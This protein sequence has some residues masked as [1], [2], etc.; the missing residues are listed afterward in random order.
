V[1]GRPVTT[2]SVIIPCFNL[3]AY[4]D[5]CVDSVLGP[6]SD[7]VEVLIVDDGSTE[8]ATLEALAR[9]PARHRDVQV[10]RVRFRSLPRARNAGLARTTGRHVLFLD[11]DDKLGEGFL[12][13]ALDRLAASPDRGVVFSDVHL[14]GL[15]E[16]PWRTGPLCWGGEIYLHNY[17]Q[18]CCVIRREVLDRFGGYETNMPA[19]E[20]W[21]LWIRLY[22]AGVGFVKMPG[23]LA[24][25]RK[26]ENSM[27]S[28]SHARRPRLVNQLILNHRAGY[29]RVLGCRIEAEEERHIR[30]LLEAT[31]REGETEK[32]V[33]ALRRT[34]PYRRFVALGA[35]YRLGRKLLRPVIGLRTRVN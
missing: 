10:L 9:L 15:V 35:A 8:A 20:D 25:Y 22:E 7:R 21:D 4:L 29:T 24:Y 2:V 23:A 18:Y 34:R 5:E 32:L 6:G 30:G 28:Q 11:A 26:R 12:V 16:G 1:D 14:F 27:L 17:L 19:Y 31:A 3:G 13:H 33:A